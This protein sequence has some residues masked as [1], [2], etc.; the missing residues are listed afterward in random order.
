VLSISKNIQPTI[1]IDDEINNQTEELIVIKDM[2]EDKEINI[3]NI[4]QTI[5]KYKNY[6]V[7]L[8]AF[9]LMAV[10]TRKLIIHKK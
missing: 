3:N 5:D 8:L 9:I 6:I 1:L 10:I 2:G 4:K 7:M